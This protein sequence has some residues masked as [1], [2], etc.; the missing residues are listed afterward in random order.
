[1]IKEGLDKKGE[2]CPFCGSENV[3]KCNSI[4]SSISGKLPALNIEDY[5]CQDCN[6]K[7]KR[8]K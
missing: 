3:V 1:M 2:K 7:F 8:V 6:K 4:R 5:E